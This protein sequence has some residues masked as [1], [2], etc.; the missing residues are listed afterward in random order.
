MNLR[1]L[2]KETLEQ[3]LDKTLILKQ[4]SQNYVQNSP[5]KFPIISEIFDVLSE[6]E[7]DYFVF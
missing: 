4:S 3:H 7:C 1:Q 2:I 6:Q 5:Y